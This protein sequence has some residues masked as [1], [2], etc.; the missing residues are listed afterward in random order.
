MV[1]AFTVYFSLFLLLLSHSLMIRGRQYSRGAWMLVCAGAVLLMAIVLGLRYDVGVDYMMYAQHYEQI[2]RYIDPKEEYEPAFELLNI[3][4]GRA[5]AP[6]PVFFACTVGIEMA[7]FYMA[8]ENKQQMLPFAVLFYFITGQLFFD[9]NIVRHAIATMIFIYGLRYLDSGEFWKYMLCIGFA[10]C[11]HIIAAPLLL[12]WLF[13]T[14]KRLLI[15]NPWFT[16]IIFLITL[17]VSPIVTK[18]LFEPFKDIFEVLGYNNYIYQVEDWEMEISSGLGMILHKFLDFTTIVLGL[19]LSSRIKGREFRTA[20]RTFI[21]GCWL[22]NLFGLNMLL[23]RIPFSFTSLRILLL[24]IMAW[25]IFSDKEQ[26]RF[27]LDKAIVIGIALL[28]LAVFAADIAGGA[29]KCS[30]FQFY[31]L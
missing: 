30:P 9:L 10:C 22:A 7:F 13:R 24:P 11:F 15:D 23:S 20:L 8:F 4:L 6:L 27:S 1:L 12:V 14:P 3:V 28:Y 18:L 16:S 5:G 26:P 19:L 25:S 31:S 2:G 29:S 17:A 21:I